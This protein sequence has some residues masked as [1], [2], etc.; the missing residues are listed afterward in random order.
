MLVENS[1]NRIAKI[2]ENACYSNNSLEKLGLNNNKEYVRSYT[3]ES[4]NL[5]GIR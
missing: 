5:N 3:S 1:R 4:I 2:Q